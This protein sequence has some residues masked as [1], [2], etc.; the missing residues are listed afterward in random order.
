MMPFS[1][2]YRGM[3]PFQESTC[4]LAPTFVVRARS[5]FKVGLVPNLFQSFTLNLDLVLSVDLHGIILSLLDQ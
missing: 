4:L 1:L 5:K 2:V 3:C